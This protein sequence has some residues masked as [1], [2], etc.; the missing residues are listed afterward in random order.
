MEKKM[1]IDTKE[2][3]D[4]YYGEKNRERQRKCVAY[5]ERKNRYKC[6]S[7][8]FLEW[9]R[10]KCPHV[11]EKEIYMECIYLWECDICTKRKE[12]V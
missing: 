1:Y 11:E 12:I 5:Q 10:Y 6:V 8:Y 9:I 7:L 2:I 3:C 4:K